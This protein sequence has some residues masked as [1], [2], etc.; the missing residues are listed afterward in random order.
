MLSLL[1]VHSVPSANFP[2]R[3]SHYRCGFSP[4][5]LPSGIIKVSFLAFFF[6]GKGKEIFYLFL[7]S[8]F[9]SYF[10]KYSVELQLFLMFTKCMCI[11]LIYSLIVR[12]TLESKYKGFFTYR[13]THNQKIK[14][15]TKIITLLIQAKTIFFY[16]KPLTLGGT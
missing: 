16:Q 11:K 2:V 1:A 13:Q 15:K 6:S 4:P 10:A 3:F 5:Q 9:N 12:K 8:N 7:S 14:Q